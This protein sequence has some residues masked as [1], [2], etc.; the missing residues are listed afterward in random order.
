LMSPLTETLRL[1]GVNGG[2]GVRVPGFCNP[3]LGIRI[4]VVR[5]AIYYYLAEE[6]GI[7]TR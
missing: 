2:A 1:A 7:R 3:V 5:T 4:P 6:G